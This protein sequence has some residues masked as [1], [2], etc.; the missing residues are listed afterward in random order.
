QGAIDV[1]CIGTTTVRELVTLIADCTGR[2][3]KLK[4]GSA[5]AFEKYQGTIQRL[6]LAE[7]LNLPL[8]DLRVELEKEL[9]K[10]IVK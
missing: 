2:P 8:F 3:L 9:K 4:A 7:K 10:L 1:A 5:S 6:N